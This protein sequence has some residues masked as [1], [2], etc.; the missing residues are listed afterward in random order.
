MTEKKDIEDVL[1]FVTKPSSY[2]GGEINSVQKTDSADLLIALC[3]PDVY[4]IGTSHFGIQILYNILNKNKRIKAERVFSPG[5]DMESCLRKANRSVFSL[6]TR[7][8]L[9]D[10][11]VIG[12]S[13]LYELNYT[14][15]LALLDISGIPYYASERDSSQPLLIGGGPCAVNPEPLADFFDAFLIG[16]GEE[17]VVAMMDIWLEFHDAG[18][19]H[20][21]QRLFQRWSQIPGIYVPSFFSTHYDEMGRQ[22]LIPKNVSYKKISKAVVSELKKEDFPEAPIVPFGRPVHDRLRLEIARGCS[23]GC[24]FCQAGMIYRPVRERNPEDVLALAGDALAATGYKDVSFLS[25]STGDY[26]QLDTLLASF[27]RIY[28]SQHVAISLPSFRAGSLNH[29]AM[30][31]IQK[32]RKTGFTIAPEAGSQRLRDVINKNITE[33]D[34]I[35]TV[36]TAFDLGWNLIK[37]YF[38]I[39]L[40]TETPDDVEQIVALVKRLQKIGNTRG[41]ANSKSKKKSIPPRINVSVATFIPKPHTPF[42][43][44]AQISV[45]EATQKIFFLKK[46][47]SS[48]QIGFKWQDPQMSLLEGVFARGDR[49]LSRLIE[50]AYKKGCRFDGW[51][52]NFRFSAWQEAARECSIDFDFYTARPRKTDEPLPWNR[53]SAGISNQFLVQEREKAYR[54]ELTKDCREGTCWQCGVCDFSTNSSRIIKPVLAAG[55]KSGQALQKRAPAYFFE[56]EKQLEITPLKYEITYSKTGPARYFGHIEF[57]NI[58]QRAIN[59]EQIPV[60]FSQG[61]H[62]KPKISFISPLPVGI[63]SEKEFFYLTVFTRLNEKKVLTAMNGRLPEGIH[64]LSCRLV[65]AE[66]RKSLLNKNPVVRYR[67]ILKGPLLFDIDCLKSFFAAETFWITVKGKNNRDQP[68]ELREMIPRME[69][70]DRRRLLLEIREEAGKTVRPRDV[71]GAVFHIPERELKQARII[72]RAG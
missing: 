25:L 22:S 58:L 34:I 12:I 27:T 60:V 40:P 59:R 67:V 53:I 23:K 19:I 17:A 37:V 28:G 2:L 31:S 39:G 44:E 55:N 32:I 50:A 52:D 68:K 54:G 65:P 41:Q 38:M 46:R 26:S 61:F 66:K 69:I 57:A 63:E 72:K 24:R 30:A 10:F 13:L 42:Q 35:H 8:A 70:L 14:N 3:F 1:P 16:D 15:I 45:A 11:D 7:Q 4:E 36:S 6:E 49:R 56:P 29:S 43:W 62:P 18:L 5:T 71:L 33:A 9:N 48:R 47:L 20:D 21:R 51:S 64:L